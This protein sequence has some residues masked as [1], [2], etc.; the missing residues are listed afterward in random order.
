[1]KL[2]EDSKL[3][4]RYLWLVYRQFENERIEG[5][6]PEDTICSL[7]SLLGRSQVGGM[8]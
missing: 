4:H 1:M 2:L 5:L 6:F 7:T 3:T 8:S